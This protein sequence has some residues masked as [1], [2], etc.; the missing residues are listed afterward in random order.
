MR[1]L[2]L[3]FLALLSVLP[4]ANS[5]ESSTNAAGLKLVGGVS[6]SSKLEAMP[7]SERVDSD[8]TAGMS[9]GAQAAASQV[10]MSRQ[11]VNPVPSVP[12]ANPISLMSR[13]AHIDPTQ[14]NYK[15][16]LRQLAV[17]LWPVMPETA[18]KILAA[19][20]QSDFT[21]KKVDEL[22]AWGQLEP[23]SRVSKSEPLFPRMQ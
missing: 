10:D 16:L 12:R 20:G 9:S 23:E 13:P 14:D 7:E 2:S 15:K 4:A 19:L 21:S 6:H 17:A 3:C 8:V 1:G 11:V 5:Q 18:V 22:L